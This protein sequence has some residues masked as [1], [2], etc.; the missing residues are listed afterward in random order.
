MTALT[1]YIKAPVSGNLTRYTDEELRKIQSAFGNLLEELMEIRDMAISEYGN[2]IPVIEG[3][4]TPGVGTYSS[5]VGHYYKI[6][7]LIVAEMRLVTVAHTG[8]GQAAVSNLPYRAKVLGNAHPVHF[9][10]SDLNALTAALML[11][12]DPGRIRLYSGH[13]QVAFNITGSMDFLINAVYITE[14]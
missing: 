14:D 10:F 11:N 1:K 5:Q 13:P 4:T 9:I 12:V 2:F 3:V 6:G 7:R 8:T